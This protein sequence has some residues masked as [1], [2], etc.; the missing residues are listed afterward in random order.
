M[1][2]KFGPGGNSKSF[3]DAGNKHTA[4]APEWVK[5]FGLDAYE[6]EGGRGITASLETFRT[7]GEN[8][9]Q[10]GIH[11]SI[12]APYYI[13]LSSVEEEKRKNSANYIV[14]S[15]AALKELGGETIVI[16]AGSTAKLD[17][18]TALEYATE[19]LT[20]A[21]GKLEQEGLFG[22]K[23]GIETMG[24]INQL[25]TLDEVLALC[26]LD[27]TVVPVVDF[28][29][30]NAREGGGVFQTSDDYKR[31]FDRIAVEKGPE[32]AEHLH[33][34]FSKIE[35]TKGGEKVHLTFEDEIFGPDYLPLMQAIADLGVSPVI[36]CESAETMA[37]DALRMKCAYLDLIAAKGGNAI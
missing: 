15:A 34:H 25:G 3:Y 9:R 5:E 22:A 8:A 23:L 24:K 32:Y 6:Y 17:R 11:V 37:E 10:A 26:A 29:H 35:Y 16:H 13:S 2:A 30:M 28:G 7:I 33:C 31:I 19:A 20:F 36:I 27:A 18:R 1:G 21:M 14:K 4:Q 12:H